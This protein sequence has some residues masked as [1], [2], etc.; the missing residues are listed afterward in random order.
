MNHGTP[1]KRGFTLPEIMISLALL[2]FLMLAAALAIEAAHA[3]QTYNAEKTDLSLRARGTLD[4]LARDVRLCQAFVVTDA[5][6]ITIT[7]TNGD[8]R[9]YHWDGVSRGNIIFTHTPFGS[10][11]STS[12][13]LTDDAETFEVTDDAPACTIRLVLKGALTTSEARIT[14]TPR[15]A[16]Y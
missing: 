3:S 7:M 9:A 6:T 12:D 4:R 15:K 8:V 16:V 5:Q 13:I 2:T 1:S 14:S 10:L 11:V